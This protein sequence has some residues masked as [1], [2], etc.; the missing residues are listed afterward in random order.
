MGDPNPEQYDD[1]PESGE[2][3]PDPEH[4]RAAKMHEASKDHPD[5]DALPFKI[6]D[7]V[8]DAAQG[9]PM[10]V[11]ERLQQTVAEWSEA[12]NYDLTENYGNS[13][14]GADA[15][16]PVYVTAYVSDVSSQPSKT[17]TFPQSRLRLIETHRAEPEL[18]RVYDA[19]AV[20]VLRRLFGAI[21]CEG[22]DNLLGNVASGQFDA[23][24]VAEARELADVDE[25]FGGDDAE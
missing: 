1:E 15:D 21:D 14:F 4:V 6:G 20:D 19:V 23:G 8:M 17:Y 24:L 5:F 12:N 25:R 13:R 11:L 2:E 16:E 22:S 3:P 18:R 10:I 7:P 9:R